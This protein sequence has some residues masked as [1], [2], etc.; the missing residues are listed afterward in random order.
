MR[1]KRGSTVSVGED[2]LYK[3]S[4]DLVKR[5]RFPGGRVPPVCIVATTKRAVG[6][7]ELK[8]SGEGVP[9][10]TAFK[11]KKKSINLKTEYLVQDLECVLV[12][13]VRGPGGVGG[14]FGKGL[15]NWNGLFVGQRGV[16]TLKVLLR[17][18]ADCA[19]VR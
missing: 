9:W 8:N 16:Y 18:R 6:G 2:A 4:W 1:V 19:A 17:K 10:K 13:Y 5:K 12:K 14:R 7:G 3:G 15:R 11:R